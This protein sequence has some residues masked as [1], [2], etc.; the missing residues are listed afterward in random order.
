MLRVLLN[1]FHEGNSDLVL[2]HLPPEDVQQAVACKVAARDFSP[3]IAG[4]GE[5][6]SSIH[7]TWLAPA[8]QEMPET[9]HPFVLAALPQPLASKLG[10]HLA[11]EP[12]DIELTEPM[13]GF[14]LDIFYNRFKDPQVLPLPFLPVTPLSTLGSC[15]KDQLVELIDFLGVY[16]LAEEIRQI[17]DKQVLKS[18]YLCLSPKK[19]EFLRLCLHHKDKL[20]APKLELDDWEGDKKKLEI[21]LH[22]RGLYRF[23]KALSGQHPHFLWHLTHK[24][25][26][27]RGKALAKY[28]TENELPGVTPALAQQIFNVLNF[29]KKKSES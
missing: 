23:G 6:L 26:T 19:Q 13:K 22:R 15:S 9:L 16:D 18:L 12:V 14:F 24:L 25:D 3:A 20:S 11:K 7:Y 21:I 10:E 4:A 2:H 1:H 5:H 28:Y 29:L 17:I 27:G 8:F